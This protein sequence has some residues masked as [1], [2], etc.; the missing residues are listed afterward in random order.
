VIV[1]DLVSELAPGSLSLENW[2][3]LGA[4]LNFGCGFLAKSSISVAPVKAGNPAT[5]QAR[6]S[7]TSRDFPTRNFVPPF[8]A[9]Q[10]T[11]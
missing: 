4:T 8:S 6:K 2:M 9:Q 7:A 10:L 5:D 1:N 11:I 3:F